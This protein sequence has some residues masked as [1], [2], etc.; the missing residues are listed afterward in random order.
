MAVNVRIFHTK[1]RANIEP[2]MEILANFKDLPEFSPHNIMEYFSFV[3]QYGTHINYHS[4]F[5]AKLLVL[6]Y[7]NKESLKETKLRAGDTLA[8]NELINEALNMK[9]GKETKVSVFS[10]GGSTE[11]HKVKK[12]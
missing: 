7:H 3:S 1:L 6:V 4:Y 11:I 8:F 2:T 5:G 9:Q 10:S 12:K